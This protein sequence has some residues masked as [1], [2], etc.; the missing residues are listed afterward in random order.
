MSAFE[1]V[2]ND[3]LD[4]GRIITSYAA[5]GG[6]TPPIFDFLYVKV[7]ERTSNGDE[8]SEDSDGYLDDGTAM[9]YVKSVAKTLVPIHATSWALRWVKIV[10]NIVFVYKNELEDNDAVVNMISLKKSSEVCAM[11]DGPGV[12]GF[13]VKLSSGAKICFSTD[14]AKTAELWMMTMIIRW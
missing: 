3:P 6:R 11:S 13:S 5:I 9:D 7:D 12:F 10:E 1:E 14:D 4:R 8:D 2:T